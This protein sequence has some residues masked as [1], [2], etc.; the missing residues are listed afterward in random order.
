MF[1]IT[2]HLRIHFAFMKAS[3]MKVIEADGAVEQAAN[4][5]TIVLS[6]VIKSELVPIQA[7]IEEEMFGEYAMEV[8]D[9]VYDREAGTITYTLIVNW[10]EYE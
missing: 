5:V 2:P 6:D 10:E 8:D 7:V 3:L 1:N 4:P 9:C